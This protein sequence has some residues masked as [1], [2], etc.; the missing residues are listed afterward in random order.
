VPD[1]G[2]YGA[3]LGAARLAFAAATGEP[4]NSVCIKPEVAKVVRPNP[5]LVE[6]YQAGYE[7]FTDTYTRLHGH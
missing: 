6:Q 1:N 7:K 4:I 2:D 5:R 3:A